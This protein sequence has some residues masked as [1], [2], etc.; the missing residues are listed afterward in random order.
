MKTFQKCT[1]TFKFF[2]A[3]GCYA[4]L[5][6]LGAESV[7]AQMKATYTVL[8]SAEVKGAPAN[9]KTEV[10]MNIL[11][12]GIGFPLYEKANEETGAFTSLENRLD[13]RVHEFNVDFPVG[14]NEYFPETLYGINYT[15]E[16]VT[17]LN[18]KWSAVGFLSVGI[19]SDFKNVDSDHFFAEGGVLFARK[20]NN[21]TLGLGPVY[22]YAFG[23]PKLIVAP[24]VKYTS[25][26]GKFTVDVKV[27]KHAVLGYAFSDKFQT[28]LAARTLYSNYSLGDD[29]AVGLDGKSPTVVFSELTL[30]LESTVRISKP[31]A[32]DFALGTTVDRKFSANDNSGNE[33]FERE[34]KNTTFI[35]V[36]LKALF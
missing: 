29:D 1:V 4:L 14:V 9:E 11:D 27:P 15:L 34:L 18:P 36:G 35:S 32:L 10:G 26:N 8:P 2:L 20:F 16:G 28:A 24:L 7:S 22:T 12:F 17:S 23:N 13:F 6:C 3:A 21:L 19:F 33:L 5:L 25:R 30:A 31:V